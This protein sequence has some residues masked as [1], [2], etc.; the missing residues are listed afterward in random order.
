M[1]GQK[2]LNDQM[3]V[4]VFSCLTVYSVRVPY[5]T[6]ESAYCDIIV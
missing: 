1:N 2:I 4:E 3:L 6:T 5:L